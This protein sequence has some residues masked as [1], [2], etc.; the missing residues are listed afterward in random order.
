ML[1]V[2]VSLVSCTKTPAVDVR[3]NSLFRTTDHFVEMLDSA[4]EHNDPFGKKAEDRSDG[5]ITGNFILID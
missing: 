4:Y 1:L 3:F 2:G 5:N